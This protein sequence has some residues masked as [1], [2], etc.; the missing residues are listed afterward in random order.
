V[1]AGCV[2]AWET[3]DS[4]GIAQ[5]S[6]RSGDQESEWTMQTVGA[7]SRPLMK[8]E[9]VGMSEDNTE[10]FSTKIESV[11][12]PF[13]PTMGADGDSSSS[14]AK[15]MSITRMQHYN[16]YSFE[17][18]RVGDYL[19]QI[20]T[21]DRGEPASS[22]KGVASSA[23]T[24]GPVAADKS[25]NE[26]DTTPIL[27]WDRTVAA[28]GS[29][30]ISEDGSTVK[31]LGLGSNVSVRAIRSFSSGTHTWRVRV[32][33]SNLKCPSGHEML[34][35]SSH[36]SWTC[37]RCHSSRGVNPRMRCARCDHDICEK[38]CK[39]TI[40]LGI[41]SQNFSRWM[42]T[43]HA[44][45]DSPGQEDAFGFYSGNAF[46][47]WHA[48]GTP[49]TFGS[50][51]VVELT[52][53]LEQQRTLTAHNVTQ[54]SSK[55]LLCTGLPLSVAFY[56]AASV[57]NNEGSLVQLL[58]PHHL[59]APP[60]IVRT[61]SL[62][63]NATGLGPAY[64]DAW[65]G[66]AAVGNKLYCAPHNAQRVLVIDGDS[67]RTIECGVAGDGKWLGIAAVGSKL[68]CA[69]SS[70]SS[71]L[72]IDTR[73]DTVSTIECGVAGDGKWWGIAAVGTKLYCAPN[74]AS[75]VLVI[76]ADTDT[77]RKIECGVTG[78]AKWFGIAAVGSKLYCAPSS[79]SS[80]LVI[81]TRTDKLSTIECGVAGDTKWAGIAAVGSK[82]Y[83]APRNAS[84]VLVIDADTD[85]VSTIGCDV[86]LDAKYSGIA[87]LGS[88]L[89]CAPRDASSVLVIDTE[90]SSICKI[91][92]CFSGSSKWFGIAAS[93]N[94]LYCAP[95]NQSSVLVID[96]SQ[97]PCVEDSRANELLEADR[98]R[99]VGSVATCRRALSEKEPVIEFQIIFAGGLRDSTAPD[100]YRPREAEAEQICEDVPDVHFCVSLVEA[101]EDAK[102]IASVSDDGT[103]TLAG[104]PSL[105][106][107]D[108]VT[109]HPAAPLPASVKVSPLPSGDIFGAP[110]CPTAQHAMVISKGTYNSFIC[111]RCGAGKSG[112]RWFCGNCRDDFCLECEPRR[113][114]P[115]SSDAPPAPPSVISCDSVGKIMAIFP[116]DPDTGVGKMASVQFASVKALVPLRDLARK[117]QSKKTAVRKPGE[118][119]GFAISRPWDGSDMEIAVVVNSDVVERFDY[120]PSSCARQADE[121]YARL[122]AFYAVSSASSNSV[123]TSGGVVIRQLAIGGQEQEREN[124]GTR[125]ERLVS[126][127]RAGDTGAALA[128]LE[129]IDKQGLF[130]IQELLD[131][132]QEHTGKVEVGDHVRVKRS[133][134]DPAKGW[135]SV[136]HASLGVL[137][138]KNGGDGEVDFPEQRDWMC[139]LTEIES[140]EKVTT[141]GTPLHVAALCP[142][143]G[144][145][146]S[147]LLAIGGQELLDMKSSDG[148]T[149][150]E[151]AAAKSHT[152][153]VAEIDS[154][155]AQQAAWKQEEAR[156]ASLIAAAAAATKISQHLAIIAGAGQAGGFA[157][158]AP[159]EEAVA[160]DLAR[161]KDGHVTPALSALLTWHEIFDKYAYLKAQCPSEREIRAQGL[162]LLV[163]DLM[164][165]ASL[166]LF[167][168]VLVHEVHKCASELRAGGLTSAG[169]SFEQFLT[170]AIANR[171]AF[172]PIFGET[173]LKK[174][175]KKLNISPSLDGGEPGEFSATSADPPSLHVK[176]WASGGKGSGHCGK[177]SVDEVFRVATETQ[178][179]TLAVA[180]GI[181]SFGKAQWLS[182]CAR[183]AM[184][185]ISS[186]VNAS[187]DMPEV[188]TYQSPAKT[189]GVAG[190]GGT[191]ASAPQTAPA[192][193]GATFRPSDA[194][195]QEHLDEVDAS[196]KAATATNNADL[197][198]AL[199]PNAGQWLNYLR[200]LLV[201]C[202]CTVVIMLC[203][204][205]RVRLARA[206]FLPRLVGSPC[207]RLSVL[208]ISLPVSFFDV[209]SNIRRGCNRCAA[210]QGAACGTVPMAAPARSD[211]RAS[212]RLAPVT[213][214]AESESPDAPPADAPQAGGGAPTDIASSAVTTESL[215]NAGPEGSAPVQGEDEVDAG[216]EA[217]AKAATGDTELNRSG[218]SVLSPGGQEQ[219][220]DGEEARVPLECYV[221]M[222]TLLS[223]RGTL[224]KGQGGVAVG[225]SAG[226]LRL[227]KSDIDAALK[228]ASLSEVKASLRM[229]QNYL[230]KGVLHSVPNS[231]CSTI[232]DASPGTPASP[233]IAASD[234]S[235]TPPGS[236]SPA[237]LASVSSPAAPA[238]PESRSRGGNSVDDEAVLLHLAVTVTRLSS[239]MLHLLGT[240]PLVAFSAASVS[241][242]HNTQAE[243]SPS[244]SPEYQVSADGSRS[245]GGQE[246][247]E[248]SMRRL[249]GVGVELMLVE[250]KR[251]LIRK[252]LETKPISYA[253]ASTVEIDR[254]KAQ[255][256]PGTLNENTMLAQLKRGLSEQSRQG[257]GGGDR[258]WRVSYRGE[259]GADAG[260][261]FRDSLSAL[262]I[263]C[264]RGADTGSRDTFV[265]PLFV[266][267]EHFQLDSSGTRQ[268]VAAFLVP[269][270]S[271]D[272]K[273]AEDL[274]C[275]LGQI[276]GACARSGLDGKGA[277]G[278]SEK[279]GLTLAPLVWKQLLGRKIRWSDVAE[280]EPELDAHVRMIEACQ[281]PNGYVYS[282][283][284]FNTAVGQEY[285]FTVSFGGAR[286]YRQKELVPGGAAR[287]L[288]YDS[289]HDYVR[290]YKDA[291]M[292]KYD[293]QILAMRRG[294]LEYLPSALLP[295]WNG[296]DLELAV[297]GEPEVDVNKL[298]AEASVSLSGSRKKWFWQCVEEM[299]SQQRSKLLRFATGRS[300]L[301]VG[302]FYVKEQVHHIRQ[303]TG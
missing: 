158:V 24:S 251:P 110:K 235:T 231:L 244:L 241:C 151:L 198:R 53:D 74:S 93:E 148:K 162:A 97:N 119:L 146:V 96:T 284:E 108:E 135:G 253:G 297:A 112:E 268:L 161:A 9:C 272:T 221:A 186:I 134:T 217:A 143:H 255:E 156:N 247:E 98:E 276:M 185:T 223:F 133:V 286:P 6:A 269:N 292:R 230:D 113:D 142:A 60:P 122:M 109:L 258:W 149:A 170:F 138:R 51:D 249:L 11:Q 155:V 233:G 193:A 264:Q 120:C 280:L 259:Q 16:K 181:A 63:P 88:K 211:A 202:L 27:G 215:R 194:K 252:L 125:C 84:S 225:T 129:G 176:V 189:T 131:H 35:V 13:A 73:T 33:G 118:R 187:V 7:A 31:C 296:F 81:D 123:G 117:A 300:R 22:M 180:L 130:G 124:D 52:L 271:C 216:A 76:D 214:D 139:L 281:R 99:I 29:G 190:K 115:P 166:P 144:G 37:D 205:L 104:N 159:A 91:D 50:G 285:D 163:M 262:A 86:Y 19:T 137:K 20:A 229:L 175:S 267:V 224:L 100:A 227:R 206:H 121:P 17:E 103:I 195:L 34:M 136:S 78:V 279:L 261:L 70:A 58:G 232:P 164:R 294:L 44:I 201:L 128:L 301:P 238:T 179:Q 95:S 200:T 266:Q 188:M 192:Q 290:L 64:K 116:A 107:S 82:L 80:V 10:A 66:I 222:S 14:Q 46:G 167:E 85:T 226:G 4:I 101:D 48:F 168:D 257:L 302:K 240:L 177:I 178:Q 114:K 207:A 196:A 102:C 213:E 23:S 57:Y 92:C 212:S 12:V 141:V 256:T 28:Y 49:P 220:P 145:V 219:G 147:R 239:T 45:G 245:F 56:P 25:P 3:R 39:D 165:A 67:V 183:V 273:E 106:V 69:P 152:D 72:V 298:K 132:S 90:S 65:C 42:E 59:V 299:T 288:S 127:I 243:S 8:K 154:W 1:R 172:E 242:E 228:I 30:V 270:P 38:C 254:F 32:G 126:T 40:R 283:S 54:N 157:G 274:F 218:E 43:G 208:P 234:V 68:Y 295:L 250:H 236:L 197:L 83:C 160:A 153:V 47:S 87:A 173:N 289:R 182:R 265:C 79:A 282:Q 18:I 36:P 210:P 277:G 248:D 2:I 260:G 89:Y 41:V 287:R 21:T 5:Q 26:G 111:N 171:E 203:L 105:S 237:D 263:E 75:S 55:V 71:V 303:C 191:Q 246:E 150:R 291:H 209:R 174:W 184:D 94:R 199:D 77:V 204:R 15:Y 140:V 62:T 278:A 61:I 293:V 169:L 275:F